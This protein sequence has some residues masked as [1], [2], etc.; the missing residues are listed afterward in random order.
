[1]SA[2][3]ISISIIGYNEAENLTACLE[4][5]N[6]VDEIIFVDCESQDNSLE[7]ARRYTTKV[8]SRPN[9]RNLNINKQFAIDQC[10]SSWVIYLDP[11]EI[12]PP[13]TADWIRE[14]IQ[15]SSHAAFY[16]PRKNYMLG[17]WL[18]Y[19]GQYP[20]FQLRL[21][22]RGKARFP[23]KH[24]HERLEV[25]GTIGKSTF[26]LLHYPYRTLEQ[27]VNKFN[28][29]TICYYLELI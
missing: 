12:I 17:H 6:W 27:V 14:M 8:Y 1:M 22:R 28:F 4:A 10:N 18:K 15:T 2:E 23:C 5:L 13:E 24:V 3:T 25:S 29:Y 20:D 9:V 16:F 21:F 19:G 7:I 26:D 11:D